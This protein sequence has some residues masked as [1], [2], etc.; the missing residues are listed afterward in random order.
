M[1]R[2]LRRLSAATKEGDAAVRPLLVRAKDG[3]TGDMSIF[4]QI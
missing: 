1:V 2:R 3:N 4:L